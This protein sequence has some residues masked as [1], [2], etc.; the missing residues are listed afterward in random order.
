MQNVTYYGVFILFYQWTC[1]IS[2]DHKNVTDLLRNDSF[3]AI[4]TFNLF[5]SWQALHDFIELQLKKEIWSDKLGWQHSQTSKLN[6]KMSLEKDKK[7][8]RENERQKERWEERKKALVIMKRE[9]LCYYFDLLN[10][11]LVS[12]CRA[13]FSQVLNFKYFEF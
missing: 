13:N 5:I 4:K 8:D 7:K 2:S 6:I 10:S 1:E 12:D 3:L 11:Q 9:F